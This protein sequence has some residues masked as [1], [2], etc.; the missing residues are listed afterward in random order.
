M[1]AGLGFKAHLQN[2][3]FKKLREVSSRDVASTKR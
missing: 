1:V 3:E 2:A